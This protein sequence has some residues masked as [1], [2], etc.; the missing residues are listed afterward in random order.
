MRRSRSSSSD[1]SLADG[2]WSRGGSHELGEHA[3]VF[4]LNLWVLLGLAGSG[5]AAYV[6]QAWVPGWWM[7]I[8]LIPFA[9]VFL[10][11]GSSNPVV[12]LLG[13]AM[14][15]I[16]F[17]LTAGPTLALYTSA[18]LYKVVFLTG[19]VSGSLGLVGT[20]FPDLLKG[21][22]VYLFMALTLLVFGYFFQIILTLCG[23]PAAGML[24]ALD[25]FGALVF[26]AYIVFDY[27]R[28]MRVP[29]TLDNSVDCA[30]AIYLDIWN[31]LMILVRL[32]G[33]KK[34]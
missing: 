5:Y 10:S 17:G 19:L 12:S 8:A 1:A 29:R 34:D 13:Y 16:P 28:A 15:V 4:L 9:G 23:V 22:A 33:V 31:L 3:F 27:G 24:T 25:W 18:S 20:F 32:A 26:S 14:I 11:L 21:W 7:L 6:A 30:I 2:V